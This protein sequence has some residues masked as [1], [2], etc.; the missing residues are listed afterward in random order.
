MNLFKKRKAKKRLQI[1]AIATKVYNDEKDNDEINRQLAQSAT[2]IESYVLDIDKVDNLYAVT[3]V[4]QLL[5]NNGLAFI[6][7]PEEV[8]EYKNYIKK[9]YE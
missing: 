6:L 1:K 5:H 4:L 8:K 3:K 7:K 9:K 2:D